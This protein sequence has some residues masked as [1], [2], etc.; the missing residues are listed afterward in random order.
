MRI[1]TFAILV[2]LLPLVTGCGLIESMEK[3][4]AFSVGADPLVIECS[5]APPVNT[6]TSQTN[7]TGSQCV[8][9]KWADFQS[10]ASSTLID[11][12]KSKREY[13]GFVANE[14]ERLCGE[15]VR[16]LIV[17]ANGTNTGLDMSTTVFSALGT[18]FTPLATVHAMTAGST[19][20]SGWKT[21]IDSDV[22][23]KLTVQN[24][25]QAIQGTYYKDMGN[26][27]DQ[28][29]TKDESNIIVTSE[30]G[31]IQVIHSECTLASAE[32][33]IT[34]SLSPNTSVPA[35]ASQ[36]AAA[37]LTIAISGG[38]GAAQQDQLELTAKSPTI[39][40]IPPVDITVSKSE[41]ASQIAAAVVTEVLSKISPHVGSITAKPASAQAT[42]QL[43]SNASD[44][45]T[46][47]ATM[48]GGTKSGVTLYYTPAPATSPTPKSG[49]HPG[50]SVTF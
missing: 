8:N 5:F 20:T 49:G 36:I 3:K 1:A 16:E 10:A 12:L 4:S 18:A 46:W 43:L 7:T 31:R 23:A 14:S 48:Q 6:P 11:D 29:A 25:V 26:Y 27:V 15:F 42:V 44:A 24:L 9:R 47:A 38:A 32:G 17:A 34:A 50:E 22:Y 40:N 37:T 28:L 13:L 21:A 30:L 2:L 35:N 33:T 19:I 41:T 45:V 39:P